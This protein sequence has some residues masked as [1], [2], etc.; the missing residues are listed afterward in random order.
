MLRMIRYIS[1]SLFSCVYLAVSL[2]GLLGTMNL[3]AISS[4]P[5]GFASATASTK[6]KPKVVW[7]Q[8]RHIPLVKTFT[9]PVETACTIEFP[10]DVHQYSLVP[11]YT[12]SVSYLS[13]YFSSV[14]DRAPPVA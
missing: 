2:A 6:E 10:S 9:V 13:L 7:T 11:R 5:Q 12:H 14:G 3:P 4:G 8:R 1:L